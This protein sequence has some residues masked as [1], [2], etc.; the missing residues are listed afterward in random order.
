[1]ATQQ[2]P[3]DARLL[4]GGQLEALGDDLGDEL[5]RAGGELEHVAVHD[6]KALVVG[7]VAKDLEVPVGAN[8]AREGHGADKVRR[9]RLVLREY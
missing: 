1:M 8:L 7:D 5:A 3:A 2:Q 6:A 4:G 9:E